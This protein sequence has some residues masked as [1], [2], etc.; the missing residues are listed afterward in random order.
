MT[1]DVM[2]WIYLHTFP[3]HIDSYWECQYTILTFGQK[4]GQGLARKNGN[5]YIE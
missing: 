3:Y 4:I 5:L 1:L 2:N